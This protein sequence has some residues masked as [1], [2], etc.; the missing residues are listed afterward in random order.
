MPIP[1]YII[2][3]QGAATDKDTGVYSIFEVI[4]K[5]I[6]TEIPTPKAGE[7]VVYIE[8]QRFV[9]TATWMIDSKNGESF[10]EQFE[11]HLLVRMD[12][13]ETIMDNTQNFSFVG[14]DK[15]IYRM[16]YNMLGMMPIKNSG[17]LVIESRARKV[18]SQSWKSQ[19]YRVMVEK[20]K[21]DIVQQNEYK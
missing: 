14:P 13:G 15:S 6:I 17:T 20:Q 10:D 5:I 9:I 12:G 21:R 3:S 7:G 11:L 1:M 18:G 8:R 19:H 2:C 4:D 16:T